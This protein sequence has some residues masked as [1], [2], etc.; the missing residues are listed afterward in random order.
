MVHRCRSVGHILTG[1]AAQRRAAAKWEFTAAP[2]FLWADSQ[3]L[4]FTVGGDPCGRPR[5]RSLR[6]LGSG[7][8]PARP[9]RSRSWRVRRTTGSQGR[10]LRPPASKE[11]PSPGQRDG[12]SPSPTV[13]VM[14]RPPDNRVAG[15]TLVAARVQEAPS[16]GQ[17]DGTS[18]SPT[19][20]RANVDRR[21]A[22]IG[23]PSIV[24]L[25]P[26]RLR[27]AP[28]PVLLRLPRACLPIRPT[29]RTWR[30]WSVPKGCCLPRIP[31]IRPSGRGRGGP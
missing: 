25:G 26:A 30:P 19:G 23:S 2:A 5:P 1:F 27:R 3:P 17:R 9:L 29:C 6:P 16:P 24:G 15:A 7:T 11:P 31:A 10:P 4:E 20:F 22:L 21:S 14:A 28:W 13:A 18:P 8:G 12:T